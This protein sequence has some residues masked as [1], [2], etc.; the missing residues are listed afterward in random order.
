MRRPIKP[1]AVEL[2]RPARKPVTPSSPGETEEKPV[3][4]PVWPGTE[5][6]ARNVRD[7]DDD[8][9]MAAMRAA[10][11]LFGK[12]DSGQPTSGKA[13]SSLFAQPVPENRVRTPRE[14]AA[15]TAAEQV[16]RKPTPPS[17]EQ[18]GN[19]TSPTAGRRILPSLTE[20]DPVHTILASEVITPKRRGRPAKIHAAPDEGES[21]VA[22]SR[23]RG[24]PRK[25]VVVTPPSAPELEFVF[26]ELESTLAVVPYPA[27]KLRGYVRGEIYARWARHE[28]LRPG[29]RW[30]RRLPKVCW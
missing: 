29:E 9:Y 11:A 8:G 22:P 19:E 30:K 14:T 6:S 18:P 12:S 26:P 3:S 16:F 15:T 17:D 1:F 7:D 13:E 10:D 27:Q 20:E 25:Q 28:T 5:S 4:T 21:E 2:R 23:P 24:R